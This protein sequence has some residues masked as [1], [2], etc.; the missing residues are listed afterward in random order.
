MAEGFG[1]TPLA[2]VLGLFPVNRNQPVHALRDAIAERTAMQTLAERYDYWRERE[3][4]HRLAEELYLAEG[5]SRYAEWLLRAYK[6][7]LNDPEPTTL[8]RYS[9]DRG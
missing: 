9:G 4:A 3:Q 7:E 8:P 1:P 2:P 5:A 6:A